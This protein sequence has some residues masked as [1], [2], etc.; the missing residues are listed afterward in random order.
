VCRRCARDLSSARSYPRHAGAHGG[1]SSADEALPGVL[2]LRPIVLSTGGTRR[3]R[4]L[5]DLVH[6]P[7]AHL[8][9]AVPAEVLQV[10]T[11]VLHLFCERIVQ[12]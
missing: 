8:R 6:L 1:R 7:A 10:C 11:A 2:Q 3:V 9:P 4:V 12:L 5:P